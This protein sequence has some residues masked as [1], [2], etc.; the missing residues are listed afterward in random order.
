MFCHHH[1]DDKSGGHGRRFMHGF[2]RRG[3][4]RGGEMGGGPG[5]GMRG[6]RMFDAG[7]LRLVILAL[8]AQKPSH[9]YELIKSIET[10][11]GGVY[12]P[13]PGVIYPTLTLL[14]DMG[15]ATVAAEPGGKK[16]YSLTEEGRAHLAENQAQVDELLARMDATAAEQGEARPRVIRAMQNLRLALRMRLHRGNLTDAQINAITA[17][18]DAAAT[19]VERA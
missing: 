16:L 12:A 4:G 2:G 13:S 14:E 6:G 7:G 17:A 19:T 1:S 15:L 11:L 3:M 9:G 10:R 18:I 5:A 8:I